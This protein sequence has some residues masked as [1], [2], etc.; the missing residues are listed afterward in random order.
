MDGRV[1]EQFAYWHTGRYD[2]TTDSFSPGGVACFAGENR[3]IYANSV[4]ELRVLWLKAIH[5]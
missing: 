5:G 4:E 2:I 1:M 3:V